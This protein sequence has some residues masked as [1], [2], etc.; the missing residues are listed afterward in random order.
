MASINQNAIW[1]RGRVVG[2]VSGETFKKSVKASSGFLHSPPAICLSLESIQQIQERGVN[3]IEVTDTESGRVYTVTLTHFLQYA[4]DLQRGGYEAQKALPLSYWNVSGG[5][6]KAAVNH[7]PAPKHESTDTPAP[8]Y[9][10]PS[11]IQLTF[12]GM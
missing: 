4:F 1:T 5:H 9:A 11:E 2:T 8:K 3:R 6:V 12:M 7:T 10:A